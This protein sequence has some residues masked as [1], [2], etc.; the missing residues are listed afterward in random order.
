M[1]SETTTSEPETQAVSTEPQLEDQETTTEAV[2][3]E[4]ETSQTSEEAETEPEVDQESTGDNSD[5]AELKDWA[6]KKNLPLNDPLKIAKMYRESEKQMHETSKKS[7]EGELKKAVTTANAESGTE[8]VQALRNELTALSFKVDHP[9][10]S[11]YEGVMVDILEE[12]PWMAND[13]DAVLD[14]AKGRSLSKPTEILAARQAGSKEALAQAEQADRAAQ[15]RASATNRATATSRITPE[16]V[17]RVVAQHMGD[18]AWWNKHQEE[19]NA[20]LGG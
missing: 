13:L 1:E 12:K 3:E 18:Q 6:A 9:E 10:A 5:D 14:M 19:V 11:Q 2:N 15:P 20:A 17:D 8:E 16:N 4:A 7:K